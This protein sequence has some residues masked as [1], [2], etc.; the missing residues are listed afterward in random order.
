MPGPLTARAC[1]GGTAGDSNEGAATLYVARRGWHTD[2]GFDV[3]QLTAPLCSIAVKFP[4]AKYLF[5]G[6]GDRRYLLAK[7]WHVPVLMAAV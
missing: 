1:A 4:G 6:F 3:S 7:H 5:F 2:V